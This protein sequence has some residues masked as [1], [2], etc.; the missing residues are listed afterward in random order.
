MQCGAWTRHELTVWQRNDDDGPR[1]TDA[2]TYTSH[3][4]K[5]S[6][7]QQSNWNDD[8]RQL[9]D[10]VIGLMDTVNCLSWP[11]KMCAACPSSCHGDTVRCGG[12]ENVTRTKKQKSCQKLRH[13]ISETM[14]SYFLLVPPEIP[15]A[16]TQYRHRLVYAPRAHV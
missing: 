6:V 13:H 10:V 1:P 5:R 9:K 7:L 11:R 8:S 14:T 15:G 12:V 3:R 16:R 2:A 4:S